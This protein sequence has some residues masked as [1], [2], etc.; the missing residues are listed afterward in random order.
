MKA[1]PRVASVASERCD[2]P[3]TDIF[4]DEKKHQTFSIQLSQM[5]CGNDWHHTTPPENKSF[6]K[7]VDYRNYQFIKRS[8]G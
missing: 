3:P 4:D 6:A 1:D 7:A 5:S 2:R 8:T